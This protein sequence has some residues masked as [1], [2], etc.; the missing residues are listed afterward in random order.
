M[1]NRQRLTVHADREQRGAT[2]AERVHREADGEAVDRPRHDLVCLGIDAGALEQREQRRAEPAGVADKSSADLVRHARKR[3][4]GLGHRH[5]HHVGVGDRELLVDQS[6]DGQRPGLGLHLRHEQVDVDPVEV[7]VGGHE[8]RQPINAEVGLRRDGD[9]RLAR[10]RE[11]DGQAR[12]RRTHPSLQ[13]PSDRDAAGADGHRS[14]AEL[15]ERA[16]LEDVA[17]DGDRC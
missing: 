4:V 15:E 8:G 2:I 17:R 6:L 14:G 7:A 9:E 12:S 10:L 13:E 16:S 1:G 11:D 5:R 3:D